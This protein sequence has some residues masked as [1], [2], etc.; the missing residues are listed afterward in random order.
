MQL[1]PSTLNENIGIALY[2]RN[3][4]QSSAHILCDALF[5]LSTMPN[6]LNPS[7]TWDAVPGWTAL[8]VV[9]RWF[10]FFGEM[11]KNMLRNICK[12]ANFYEERNACRSVSKTMC[13]QMSSFGICE[14]L[15][16]ANSS[17]LCNGVWNCCFKVTSHL[18]KFPL[19]YW[20]RVTHI[21]VSELGHRW[22]R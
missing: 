9:Y 16:L 19:T 1:H 2:Q 21:C 20:G 7:A 15:F 18:W 5:K 13:K 14:M 12:D 11:L 6:Q 3:I 8:F 4:R 10:L 22:F 17:K